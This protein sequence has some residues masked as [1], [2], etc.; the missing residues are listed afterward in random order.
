VLLI[1][2]CIREP[3]RGHPEKTAETSLKTLLRQKDIWVLALFLFFWNFS[4]SF[5]APFFYYSVDTLKF[6]GAFLGQL[7][8][9][10]SA[11]ALGG[12]VIYGIWIVKIP[13]RKFLIFSVFAG[14]T[15]IFFHYVYFI[16][17]LIANAPL[18]KMT[19]MTSNFLFGMMSS[20]ILLALLNLAAKVSPQYAGGTVFALLMSFYNLGLLGSSALGGFL[21][22]F[23]GL[24]LLLFIS[25]VFSLLVLFLMPWLP[26]HEKLTPMESVIQK[27]MVKCLPPRRSR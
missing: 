17:A 23:L 20:F 26:L 11:G 27:F 15:V 3:K 5:G 9:A 22:P 12:S 25:A 7:Q 10:A 18:L 24:K 14:V 6:S 16:P 21:Y 8:A 13:L 2:F 19:S 1:T 4:P